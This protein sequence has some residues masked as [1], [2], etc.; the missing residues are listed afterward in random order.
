MDGLGGNK[1]GLGMKRKRVG[2]GSLAGAGS[3]LKPPQRDGAPTQALKAPLGLG[4]MSPASDVVL[5]QALPRAAMPSLSGQPLTLPPTAGRDEAHES[6]AAARRLHC[7]PP[8]AL[9]QGSEGCTTASSWLALSL[10][11]TASPTWPPHRSNLLGT[12]ARGAE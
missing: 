7:S 12:G 2:M 8:R 4:G 5:S 1:V 10:P 9:V 11:N 6:V 3:A